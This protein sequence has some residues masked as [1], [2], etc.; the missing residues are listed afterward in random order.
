MAGPRRQ[1]KPGAS[2]NFAVDI[3]GIRGMQKVLQAL[4]TTVRNAVLQPIVKTIAEAGANTA[5]AFLTRML[6]HRDP[7][8]RRWDRPTGALADSLGHKVIP[9]S[10]MR[11]KDIVMG[12]Y[13]TRL[14]FRVAASTR[15]GVA[16][17]QRSA[18]GPLAIGR[19]RMANGRTNRGGRSIQPNKYIHLVERG[20]RGSPAHNIPPARAYP[21]MAASRMSLNAAMPMIIRQQF[22]PRLMSSVTKLTRRYMRQAGAG[23]T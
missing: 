5:R 3:A 12:M 4:P 11:N 7:R 17:I 1:R 8:T 2:I 10:K 18:A 20:H 23:R 13:G 16:S 22:H 21:F 19:I 9:P 14:D 6:P 15:R